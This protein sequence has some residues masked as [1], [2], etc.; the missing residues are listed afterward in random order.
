MANLLRAINSF[1]L[2]NSGKAIIE[3]ISNN[4]LLYSIIFLG[5]GL[6]L[7]YARAIY[8]FYIPKSIGKLVSKNRELGI[9]EIYQIWLKKKR[10][11]SSFIVVPTKN[12][13][14]VQKLNSTN[15][16]YE[17][18]LFNKKNSYQ[19]EYELLTNIYQ[20]NKNV[21]CC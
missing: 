17:V 16:N 13:I 11:L 4:Q 10:A 20:K 7:I 5:Y 15:G 12:E 18:L 9:D 14:W 6:L 1:T 21:K 8:L 19:S 2:G 3:N